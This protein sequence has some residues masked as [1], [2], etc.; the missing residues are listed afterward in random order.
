MG[1][2][3][4]RFV[5]F[6]APRNRSVAAPY[7]GYV[8][9]VWPR[10]PTLLEMSYAGVMTYSISPTFSDSSKSLPH[11]A[12]VF[13]HTNRGVLWFDRNVV[14]TT[15]KVIKHHSMVDVHDGPRFLVPAYACSGP[16]RVV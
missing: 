11:R 3:Q 9:R 4:A 2:R 15:N 16:A 14:E 8:V 12:T 6:P 1:A 13:H 5:P 10:L 7:S